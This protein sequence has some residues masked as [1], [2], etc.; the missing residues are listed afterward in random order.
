L[1]DTLFLKSGRSEF[2]RIYGVDFASVLNRGS[3]LK[4]ESILFRICK[5]ES[6]VLLSPSREE[7]GR[8]N[9][10][11]A[12]PLIAEP[13]SAFYKDPL[14]V[15][16]FQSLYPSVMIG[17][18]Y[19]FSTCLGRV[20]TFKGTNKFG[21]VNL[22]V[23]DGLLSLLKDYI[24]I[25]PNGFIFVKPFVRRSTLAK[26]LSELLN[27]RVMVKSSMKRIKDDKALTRIYNARQLGLKLLANVTYGY[28]SATFS[29]RMPCAEIADAIVQTG[30]ETLERARNV[31]QSKPDV[32]GARV[33]YGD[34]DSLFVWLLGKTRDQAHDIG[35]DMSEKVT[36]L[37]PEPVKLKF[38]KV[39]LPCVLASKKRYI[40]FKYE[41]KTEKEAVFDAKGIETVRRDGFPA[42]Q[43]MVE[44][45]IR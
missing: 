27:T 7:V 28:T 16:D 13:K 29:G 23:P 42:M 20:G 3:Q 12:M 31:I 35:E 32:W 19:C 14:C 5:P 33:V 40:G 37:N 9:A 41:Y 36:M 25:S 34:T 44:A 21:V 45:S 10:L 6:F 22:D 39:Y 11:E 8:Q 15:M 17:Y 18:N 26:M 2:A 43:K 38:E 1:T 4:V 24:N 30:R